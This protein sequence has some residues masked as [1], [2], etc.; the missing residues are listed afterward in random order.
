[1]SPVQGSVAVIRRARLCRQIT[2]DW[3]DRRLPG[4]E[5]RGSGDDLSWA[6][7]SA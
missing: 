6:T 2:A 4:L 3:T 5:L 7:F 1:L